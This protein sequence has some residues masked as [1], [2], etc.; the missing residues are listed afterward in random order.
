LQC[1]E[2][3]PT[4][5]NKFLLELFAQSGTVVVENTTNTSHNIDPQNLAHRLL[6][7]RDDM[8]RAAT[9]A[10][11]QFVELENTTVLRTHLERSTFVSG[12]HADAGGY[13][14]RRGYFNQ[15]R[16]NGAP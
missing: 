13:K 5:G 1:A 16:S 10:L 6:Q 4:E 3:P 8:A 7:I 12:S 14:D 2:H 15:R 11:P 9:V